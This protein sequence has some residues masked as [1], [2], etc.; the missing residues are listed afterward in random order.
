MAV[1]YSTY[2]TGHTVQYS[3]VQYSTVQYSTYSTAQYSTVQYSTPQYTTPHGT[4]HHKTAQGP[5]LV[6]MIA[7]LL[8]F[9]PMVGEVDDLLSG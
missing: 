6:D 3:T 8:H 2:S 5:H 9:L 1:Q 7:F 4:T